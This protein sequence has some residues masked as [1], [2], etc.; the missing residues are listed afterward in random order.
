MS[1]AESQWTLPDDPRMGIS[2]LTLLEAER[3][4][5]ISVAGTTEGV[6]CDSDE[7]TDALA[8]SKPIAIRG[9]ISSAPSSRVLQSNL[10]LRAIRRND[11]AL[12]AH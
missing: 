9:F 7:R 6:S 12:A 2:N 4:R 3:T 10:A 1:P 11:S 8:S 5:G